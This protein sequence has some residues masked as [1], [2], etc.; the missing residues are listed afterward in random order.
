MPRT[1][2]PCSF[3]CTFSS[4][5][6]DL[7][8]LGELLWKWLVYF[9][10]PR[11]QSTMSCLTKQ[12][13]CPVWLIFSLRCNCRNCNKE[14]IRALWLWISRPQAR[15]ASRSLLN[16]E[17]VPWRGT[18]SSQTHKTVQTAVQRFKEGQNWHRLALSAANEQEARWVVERFLVRTESARIQ[19]GSW[20]LF[21]NSSALSLLALAK[22]CSASSTLLEAPL[23]IL[24][25]KRLGIACR[26]S[27][28]TTAI[29]P[30]LLGI[31]SV[32]VPILH[33]QGCLLQRLHIAL[34]AA[35]S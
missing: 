34:P 11:W 15:L 4:F 22:A 13:V 3:C 31:C 2:W 16:T 12:C 35:T 9:A 10:G 30:V 17:H 27:S 33:L 24:Y 21:R 5:L 18:F 6:E 8:L 23:A 25:S 20:P 28:A 26:M 1:R 29:P 19:F 32:L 14:K 7:K